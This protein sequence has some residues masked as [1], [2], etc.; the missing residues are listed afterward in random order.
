MRCAA[1]A[2]LL[3]AAGLASQAAAGTSVL[4]RARLS[5]EVLAL[6]LE[7]GDAMVVLSAARIRAGLEF[8]DAAAVPDPPPTTRTGSTSRS[9]SLSPEGLSGGTPLGAADILAIARDMAAGDEALLG[10]IDDAE[11]EG[12]RG[13]ATGQVYSISELPDGGTDSYDALPFAAGE[14]AEV[15]VESN[16]GSDLNLFVYDAQGQLV[17]SDTDPSAISYCGW[18]PAE[19]GSFRIEVVN[20]GRSGAGYALMTN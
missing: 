7:T 3:L 6:G 5:A 13:V 4:D 16:D 10:L 9:M 8:T 14:Y 12:A 20:N 11:A 2:S 1:T 17:C 19:A 18:H 15:Y